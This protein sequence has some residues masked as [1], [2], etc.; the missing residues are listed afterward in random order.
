MPIAY[1]I[2]E[3]T[4]QSGVGRSKI[5]EA[6]SEGKLL[7]RKMGRRTLILDDDLRAWLERLPKLQPS[8]LIGDE[9]P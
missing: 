1:T 7:A 5:Y 2:Q 4:R 9:P 8:Q 6:I 3:A